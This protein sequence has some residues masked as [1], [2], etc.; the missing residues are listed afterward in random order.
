MKEM[1][2]DKEFIKQLKKLLK[3]N[4]RDEER[5]YGEWY[6]EVNDDASKIPL[7][8]LHKKHIYYSIRYIKEVLK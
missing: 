4:E 3:Y 1:L 8:K 2:K 6:S 7:D 5:H